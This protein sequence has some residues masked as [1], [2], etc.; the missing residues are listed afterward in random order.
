MLND[1]SGEERCQR[2]WLRPQ[3]AR[4]AI[5]A[6]AFAVGLIACRGNQD[7]RVLW[8]FVAFQQRFWHGYCSS[9]GPVIDGDRLY[10]G[11]GYAWND[12][13]QLFA[14]DH[15]TGR[16]L[17]RSRTGGTLGTGPVVGGAFVA[18]DAGT[19]LMVFSK[20][21]GMPI[22]SRAGVTS[23]WTV[24][25]DTVYVDVGPA[26]IAL[27]L[28]TGREIWRLNTPAPLEA[29]P[30]AAGGSLY[31]GA[32]RPPNTWLHVV[33]RDRGVYRGDG[34]S[35]PGFNGRLAAADGRVFAE[36]GFD[37]RRA[38]YEWTND[39]ETPTLRDEGLLAIQDQVAYFIDDRDRV[40]AV[41]TADG[42]RLWT[43]PG[44]PN[45]R[46]GGIVIDDGVF[47]QTELQGLDRVRAYDFASGAELWNFRSGDIIAPPALGEQA[48]F[49]SSDDCRVLALRRG[50]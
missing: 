13:T 45:L 42:R 5:T 37:G 23:R 8:R 48:L 29:S 27:D 35:L 19:R 31:F 49:V 22:W 12:V 24:A 33:D 1:R 28:A 38:T 34:R 17:W 6:L 26:I 41:D 20:T 21:D 46:H 25:D 30:V 36:A 39:T 44:A 4:R 40:T 14:L 43:R 15:S 3:H 50:R 18:V 2:V 7:A 16:E 47:Y 32:G 10:V 11:N 9:T